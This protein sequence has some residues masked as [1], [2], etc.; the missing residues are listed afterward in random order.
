M[1]RYLK[2]GF[3]DIVDIVLG[4]DDDE[5][6]VE[7]VGDLMIELYG[8]EGVQIGFLERL[9]R[10]ETNVYD[11]NELISLL[12]RMFQLEDKVKLLETKLKRLEN[13]YEKED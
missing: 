8:E 2:N 4:G 7:K 6:I 9:R 12:N 11:G 5:G 13:W 3:N 1:S 10:L